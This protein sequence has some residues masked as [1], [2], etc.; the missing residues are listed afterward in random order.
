M[1]L[2]ALPDFPWDSLAPY[3]ERASSLA[4]GLV[5]L[6]VG[7]PVDPTPDVVQDALRDAAD[8][9]GY[10]QTYGTPALREAV[11]GWF[12]RR[13][14]VPGLDPDGVMPTI[15]SKE[16]VAWLPTLLG[17]GAGDI[18]GFPGVAYPTY[19]VGA[20]LA[21]ARPQVVDGLA[22]L[23]PLTPAT[24]PK[25]L[26]LN[27]PS[28]PTGRVLGVPHLAKVVAWARQHGVVV[29]SDECYAELD[30][31]D[32]ERDVEIPT[33]PSILDPRVCGG[34]HE[35]LLAVYS[36]SKQSNLAGY[37][38]AFVAG[39]VALVRQLLEVRKH[40]GM[41]VPWPVQQALTAALGDDAHVAAQK[42]RYAAR[43]DLLRSAV[44]G[45]GMR[46]DHSD[47]GLY[48]WA[49]RGEDAWA[50]IDALAARGI[51]AAPGSFYGEAGREHVRIALTATDER[52]ATAVER[53][54]G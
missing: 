27:S 28:N 9:P 23:G 1:S 45:F 17:L 52:I 21:G 51:L 18:V 7:T 42:A 2:R 49:T 10:P 11:A 54:A 35:G 43:R 33:T 50:T 22:A 37:R 20:R 8:A 46:V 53:L 6:S 5:D 30:W 3:K 12:E 38:A 31:S 13:R 4:G 48:L 44:E 24:T 15:G 32:S 41:I 39:D 34:S 47:A 26:W 19:D 25:L 29:A 16:L 14:G 36:L 40:A